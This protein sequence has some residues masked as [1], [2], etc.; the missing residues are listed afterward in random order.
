MMKHKFTIVVESEQDQDHVMANIV[1][2]LRE[3]MPGTTGK[4]QYSIT[5]KVE[6]E[7]G[8][9]PQVQE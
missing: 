2:L 1:R 9:R 6:S 5:E 8:A 3:N 7:W 4:V